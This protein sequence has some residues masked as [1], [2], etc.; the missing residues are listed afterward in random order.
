MDKH[1]IQNIARQVLNELHYKGWE[2]SAVWQQKAISMPKSA[3][4]NGHAR[5]TWYIDFTNDQ[6]SFPRVYFHCGADVDEAWIK[7]EITQQLQNLRGKLTFMDPVQPSALPDVTQNGGQTLSTE[8]SDVK[9]GTP[10]EVAPHIV[11]A[12]TA[13]ENIFR[14]NIVPQNTAP[15][16][17]VAPPEHLKIKSRVTT[18]LNQSTLTEQDIQ[19]EQRAKNTAP[20]SAPLPATAALVTP[21]VMATVKD[22]NPEEL[23]TALL[24]AADEGQAETVR[25][26]LNQ[27]ADVNARMGNGMTALIRASFF[28]HANVVRLLL[29]ENADRSAKDQLGMTAFDWALSKD[30]VEVIKLFS[31]DSWRTA[32]AAAVEASSVFLEPLEF[33]P[34]TTAAQADVQTE[35]SP[36]HLSAPSEPEAEIVTHLSPEIEAASVP[37]DA[38]VPFEELHTEVY[39]NN[40]ETPA[41]EASAPVEVQPVSHPRAAVQTPEPTP[42]E[43]TFVPPPRKNPALYYILAAVFGGLIGFL[44]FYGLFSFRKPA[45]APVTPSNQP[46]ATQSQAQDV[47]ATSADSSRGNTNEVAASTA[48]SLPNATAGHNSTSQPENVHSKT[49][50][51]PAEKKKTAAAET[52][53]SSANGASTQA[54]LNSALDDWVTATNNRDVKKQMSFYAPKVGTFYRDRNVS[55]DEVQAEK[56]RLFGQAKSVDIRAEKPEIK[57][58]RSGRTATMRFHKKYQIDGGG[59]ARRGEVVQELQWQ[60]TASGWK[61]VGERDVRVIH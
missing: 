14:P 27:G 20:L 40:F 3:P 58:D 9:K 52:Q 50:Q 51:L 60:K 43:E 5:K 18:P 59:E 8:T 28:G 4:E 48:A 29:M 45:S 57:L 13:Q 37:G 10:V 23:N 7:S 35:P 30:Q 32:P 33:L 36:A 21:P 55:R 61:I 44:V 24:R 53:T 34:E 12:N 54:A 2:V 56:A 49:A 16:I 15:K 19:N 26:L 11:S 31:D 41:A 46:T 47:P 1:T 38:G 6:G 42:G 39:Q 25:E 17:T 22:V